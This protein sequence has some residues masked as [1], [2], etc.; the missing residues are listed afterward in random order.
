[1]LL[2]DIRHRLTPKAVKVRADLEVSC[3]TYDGIDAVKKAL[4]AGLEL[5]TE[6]L[7]IRVS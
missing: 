7:P 1:M 5:N 6:M 3:F 2:V 4:R